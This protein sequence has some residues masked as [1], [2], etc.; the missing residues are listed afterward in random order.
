MREDV[1][2]FLRNKIIKHLHLFDDAQITLFGKAYGPVLDIPANKLEAAL[3]LCE[4]TNKKFGRRI[5]EP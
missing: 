4:R 2:E 1:Q 3:A 5:E